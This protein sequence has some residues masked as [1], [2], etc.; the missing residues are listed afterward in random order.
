M[1][2]CRMV[3][4]PSTISITYNIHGIAIPIDILRVIENLSPKYPGKM[5]QT[6]RR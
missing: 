2:E 1:K 3:E 5:Q 4:V 6:S